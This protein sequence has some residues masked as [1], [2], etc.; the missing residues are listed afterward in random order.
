MVPGTVTVPSLVRVAWTVTVSSAGVTVWLVAAAVLAGDVVVAWLDMAGVELWLVV[1]VI[2]V[3]VTVVLASLSAVADVYH[4]GP[5]V[6]VKKGVVSPALILTSS[7][8]VTVMIDILLVSEL[9]V[10]LDVAPTL[11]GA[12][13]VAVVVGMRGTTIPTLK[14]EDASTDVVLTGLGTVDEAT[15]VKGLAETD[16]EG[17]IESVTESLD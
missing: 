6:V 3:V 4:V 7:V 11:M 2:L 12:L 1:V 10:G 9:V 14:L 13:G 8:S 17:E 5:N 16:S 15:V